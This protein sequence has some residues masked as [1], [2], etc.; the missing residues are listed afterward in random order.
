MRLKIIEIFLSLVVRKVQEFLCHVTVL[1]SL[2]D[3]DDLESL[4]TRHDHPEY[5]NQALLNLLH[6]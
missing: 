5:F 6:E 2:L 1:N 3:L 4:Q